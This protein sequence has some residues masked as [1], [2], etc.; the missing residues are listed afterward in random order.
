MIVRDLRDIDYRKHEAISFHKMLR[1]Y[2]SYEH[3]MTDF[4]L[5]SDAV[6]F[7]KAAHRFVFE[8]KDDIKVTPKV[9]KRTKNGKAEFENFLSSVSDDDIL[10][11]NDEFESL[12]MM[13]EKLRSSIVACELLTSCE[14][15]VSIFADDVDFGN[16]KARIDAIDFNRRF[17]IDYKTT[18]DASAESFFYD[19]KKYKYDLQLLFYKRVLNNLD[20]QIDR[21]FIIAQEKVP[22]FDFTIWQIAETSNELSRFS[23]FIAVCK[24]NLE[25]KTGYAKDIKYFSV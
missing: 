25:T 19:I 22:P 5:E 20:F 3:F 15:E 16:V 4:E 12:K 17:I 23:S 24:S 18:L 10:V 21:M 7:G 9:D 1:L 6:N 8:N 11:S 2:K 14:F 13:K